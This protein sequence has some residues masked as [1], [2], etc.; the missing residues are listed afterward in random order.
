MKEEEYEKGL[1]LG[2][3]AEMLACV[4]P[5]KLDLGTQNHLKECRISDG[6]VLDHFEW[7]H[8][9]LQCPFDRA[10]PS[11]IKF[12]DHAV[13]EWLWVSLKSKRQPNGRLDRGGKKCILYHGATD[14]G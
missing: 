13:K 1:E 11:S 2:T 3:L 4:I 6:Y 10:N 12:S 5:W 9:W 8:T 7:C 14:L